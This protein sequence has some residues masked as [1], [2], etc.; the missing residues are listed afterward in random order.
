MGSPNKTTYF[1]LTL[2]LLSPLL[3]YITFGLLGL[4]S[5]NFYFQLVIYAYGIVFVFILLRNLKFPKELSFLFLYILYLFIWAFNNG[6]IERRGIWVVILNNINISIF[7]TLLIIYNSRFSDGFIKKSIKIFKITVVLAAVASLIQV[8][9]PDFLNAWTLY[10]PDKNYA[11]SYLYLDRRTSIFGFIDPNE[12][13][14]S[15]IP[16]LAVLFGFLVYQT[17]NITYVIYL[18]LGAMVAF[19]SNT[20]YV[21]IGWLIVTMMLAI[22]SNKRIVGFVRYVF[23]GFLL[24]LVSYF[25]LGSLGYQL[26]EFY[27]ERLFPEGSISESSRYI[28]FENFAIFFPRTPLFGTGVHLTAEIERASMAIGSSQIHVGYLSHLVSY[29]IIGSI[30]LFGFWFLLARKLYITA[31]LT[32]YWGSFFAFLTYLWAQATLVNY[33]IFFYGLI[34]AFVFDKYFM[35]KYQESLRLKT[36]MKN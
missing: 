27:E 22:Y 19:L 33:S 30:F 3:S 21:M 25:I 7:F 2:M 36:Q 16:L 10:D 11:T 17:K 5:I 13:G 1:I 28:A 4:N 32:H 9:Y 18:L 12:A 29:G 31:K 23:I 8:F 24:F 6:E 34:F 26:G 15:F 35:D 14:L 20:R